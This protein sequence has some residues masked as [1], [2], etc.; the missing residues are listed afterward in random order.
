MQDAQGSSLEGIDLG[1][2]IAYSLLAERMPIMRLKT[3]A[4]ELHGDFDKFT[5]FMRR[6]VAVPHSEIKARLDA[7]KEAK[8]TSKTSASRASGAS[9][10]R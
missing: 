1:R 6:L 9:S 8:R 4:T 3:A 7:E 10:K 5:D 2:K